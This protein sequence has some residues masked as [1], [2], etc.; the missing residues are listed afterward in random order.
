[1]QHQTI[2]LTALISRAVYASRYDIPVAACP[3]LQ[4]AVL[5][6]FPALELRTGSALSPFRALLTDSEA[7][8]I[9]SLRTTPHSSSTEKHFDLIA[10]VS[11]VAAQQRV[12]YAS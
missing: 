10:G 8:C 6:S 3:S 1:M 2:A 5:L 11:A 4:T 9:R 12:V 7:L